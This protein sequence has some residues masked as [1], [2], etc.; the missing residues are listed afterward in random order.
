MVIGELR[1]MVLLYKMVY[2]LVEYDRWRKVVMGWLMGMVDD[3]T[4]CWKLILDSF[5]GDGRWW[6]LVLAW[7]IGMVDG[8]T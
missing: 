6:N 2:S 4:W 5:Y 7:L 3:G 1:S 8:G